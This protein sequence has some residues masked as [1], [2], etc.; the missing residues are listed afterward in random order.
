MCGWA[1]IIHWR[2]SQHVELIN[3]IHVHI[4]FTLEIENDNELK[5]LLDHY[6]ENR[7]IG[8]HSSDHNQDELW[9]FYCYINHLFNI[10][11]F[12]LNYIKEAKIIK[13]RT[14]INNYDPKIVDWIIK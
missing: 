13:Q 3:K 2:R 9:G 10:P 11:V 4:K 14:V 12:D 1:F 7:K 5:Y 6:K 8:V